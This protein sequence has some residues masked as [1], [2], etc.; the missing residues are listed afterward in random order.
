MVLSLIMPASQPSVT[1]DDVRSSI[2]VAAAGLL[3]DEG[4]QAVTTRAVAQA[5]GV[6]APTIYRLFGDKD[7][8]IAAVAEHAMESYVADTAAAAPA[9]DPVS[10]LRAAWRRH[11]EFGVANAELTVLLMTSG[12]GSPSP[13]TSAGIEVLRTR[14]RRIAEAGLL[15]V[16]EQRAVEMIDA[17]GTGTVL[18]LIGTAA[19]RRDPSLSEVMFDAVAGAILATAPAT[20]DRHRARSPS[21]S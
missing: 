13:A 9:E 15:R 1:R 16:T 18:A 17:A 3:R 7:G 20:P 8:L 6:Q 12:R 11:V 19:G 21:R 5:A 10:D 2:V 4:A 14:V